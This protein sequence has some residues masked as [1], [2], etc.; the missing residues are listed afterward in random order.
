MR[1]HIGDFGLWEVKLGVL[2]IQ[3]YGGTQANEYWLI[4]LN[5]TRHST[6]T[7]QYVRV[8]VCTY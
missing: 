3:V 5:S 7:Y 2:N 6:S 8:V 4:T 1:R